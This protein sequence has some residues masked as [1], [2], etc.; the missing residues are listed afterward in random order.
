M[1]DRKINEKESFDLIAQMIRNT[2]NKLEENS[3]RPFLLF[4]YASVIFA[5][6]IWYLI[7]M[8]GINSWGYLWFILP[9]ICWPIAARMYNKRKYITTYID[10]VI[11]YL[12]ILTGIVI[13]IA[14]GLTLIFWEMESL[15]FTVL[16]LGMSITLTGLIVR[17]KSITVA[18]AISI[19]ISPVFL[20]LNNES[21][22]LML[23][24]MFLLIFVIPGH[25][26]NRKSKTKS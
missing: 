24:G 11:K 16:I 20:W 2:Q 10:R 22:I 5:V 4:G 25:I 3:G 21:Q 1:E 26:L 15:F 19:V 8:T 13:I 17:I 12:W 9:I 7:R 18:G 23:G 14:C 6:V